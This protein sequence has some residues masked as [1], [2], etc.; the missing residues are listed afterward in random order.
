MLKSSYSIEAAL[1]LDWNHNNFSQNLKRLYAQKIVS[2]ITMLIN[3]IKEIAYRGTEKKTLAYNA[4]IKLKLGNL[5]KIYMYEIFLAVR[6]L[7][8]NKILLK[9]LFYIVVEGKIKTKVKS[10]FQRNLNSCVYRSGR[11]L[12]A[13]ELGRNYLITKRFFTIRKNSKSD[14]IDKSLTNEIKLQLDSKKWITIKQKKLLIKHIEKCQTNLSALITK[15]KS[16]MSK[17]FYVVEVLL[18]SLL[19]QVYTVEIF[20]A[21][22]SSKSVMTDCII[23]NNKIQKKLVCLK[24]LRKFRKRKL[25]PLKIIRI[26]KKSDEK[27]LINIPCII[28]HLIQQLFILVLNPIIEVNSDF[29]SYGSRKGRSSIRA[30]GDIQKNL[31]SKIRKRSTLESIFVWN[32]G[33]KKCSDFI[34]R[35]WLIKSVPFPIKYKYIF[36]NW[37]N[38]YSIKFKTIEGV[39]NDTKTFQ[40]Y[41]ISSLL[42]N[43]AL[44][45]IETLINEEIINY[46]KKV[47]KSCLKIYRNGNVEL[48]IFLK[49]SDGSFKKRKISCQFFRYFDNFIFICSSNKLLFLIKKRINVFLKLRGLQI[50]PNKSQIILFNSNASF[51]FLGYTFV[52]LACQ[53]KK[54]KLPHRQNYWYRHSRSRLFVYPTKMAIKLFK[55]SLKAIIINNQSMSAYKLII[56]LNSIIRGWVKYYL[57][58]SVYNIFWLLCNW[59][60]L[61]I[62]IWMKR[63]H[64]KS[65]KNWLHRYYLSLE[66]FLEKYDLKKKNLK[67]QIILEQKFIHIK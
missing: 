2:Q 10:L 52:Y 29:H 19:F 21:N 54:S 65:S 49:L 6:I 16:S 50:Q 45:G 15:N 36:K 24:K 30:I 12:L 25:L 41:N 9:K 62:R 33:I 40:G 35:E 56:I 47:S 48:Y 1:T 57:F 3:K 7:Y 39:Y 55:M 37:L 43:F 31:Q 5:E 60:Y 17:T 51:D 4:I 28:D 63:K 58:S 38:L 66:N 23:S 8:L 26:F 46:Q 34:N 27:R 44:N 14:Y 13:F 11:N 59:I 53:V 32:T 18:N 22:K 42:M 64:P 61:R 20:W 67:Q